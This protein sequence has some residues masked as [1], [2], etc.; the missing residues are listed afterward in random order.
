[1]CDLC[2]LYAYAQLLLL[3]VSV[4]FVGQDLPALRVQ[5]HVSLRWGSYPAL[6][7]QPHKAGIKT[8]LL[9]SNLGSKHRP[10]SI[11]FTGPSSSTVRC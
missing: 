11:A 2:R 5:S 3:L 10:L 4:E 6:T 8:A 9:G 7:Q 1:M